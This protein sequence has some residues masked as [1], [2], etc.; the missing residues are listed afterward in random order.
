MP[1]LMLVLY[2]TLLTVGMFTDLR[3]RRVPN[4]LVLLL[5]AVGVVAAMLGISEATSLL[6]ALLGMALGLLL[7]IPFWLLRL[8]GAGDVK[9][10]AAAAAWIGPSGA[11]HAALMA[12]LLGGVTAV[13]LLVWQRGAR[14]TAHVV[15]IAATM[16]RTILPSASEQRSYSTSTFP[17]AVPM[18]LALGAQS[19]GYDF[20]SFLRW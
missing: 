10:F 14:G 17:Y 19:L 1:A 7:W 8:L 20:L 11:L 4:A 12:A 18:G 3:A 15:A 2:I 5:L 13:F 9:Y 16:P 6:S